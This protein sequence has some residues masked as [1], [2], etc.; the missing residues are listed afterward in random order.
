VRHSMTVFVVYRVA[1]GALV[2]ILTASGAIS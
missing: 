1:L 2:L